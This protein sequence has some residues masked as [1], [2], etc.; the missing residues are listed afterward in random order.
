MEYVTG[1]KCVLCGR[2]CPARN[3]TCPRCGIQ[4]ILDVQ[5]DYPAVSRRLTRRALAARI[6]QSHWRYRELLPIRASSA[7][8]DLAVGWTPL[9][10]APALARHIGVRE[11]FVKDDGRNATGSMKDRAS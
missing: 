3:F 4:G 5:Y 11:L 7:V 9:T 6:G 10:I 8:P 2:A 1:L